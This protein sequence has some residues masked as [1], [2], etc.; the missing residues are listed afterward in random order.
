MISILDNF[1]TR[2]ELLQ[3]IGIPNK[4]CIL[5]EGPTGTGKS[6][7]IL[8]IASYLKKDIYYL[9]FGETIKTN[10]DLQMIFDHVI[11]KR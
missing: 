11:I 1:N 10:E 7:T 3:S 5:L 8:T 6:S 2:S 9:S 4:L